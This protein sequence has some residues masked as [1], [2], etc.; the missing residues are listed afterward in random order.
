MFK[1]QLM[2]KSNPFRLLSHMLAAAFNSRAVFHREWQRY[3][4]DST[5][6]DPVSGRWIGE[7]ISEQSSHHGELKCVLIP[8]G[9]NAYRACFYANYS[10]LFSVGY[11]TKLDAR[12]AD[13][14]TLLQGQEDLGSLAGGIYR[15]EGTV[16]ESEFHCKYSCK[17][18][19]GVFRLKRPNGTIA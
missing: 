4:Q 18:D 2:S 17:Y 1:K 9:Q 8:E 3:P 7:W 11:V 15:C 10:W 5:K 19:H 12:Y 6:H 14:R 13:G 16:S